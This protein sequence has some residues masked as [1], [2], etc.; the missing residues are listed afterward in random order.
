MFSQ[1]DFLKLKDPNFLISDKPN[2][3]NKSEV[4]KLIST[5]RVKY[6][7]HIYDPQPIIDSLQNNKKYLRNLKK[8]FD[9]T[10]RKNCCNCISLVLYSKEDDDSEIIDKYLPSIQKTI[11]NVSNSLPDFIV[12]IYIETSVLRMLNN[13]KNEKGINILNNFYNAENVEIYTYFCKSLMNKKKDIFEDILGKTRTFRYLAMTDPTTN[14]CA[15]REC[16]GFV[17]NLDCHNLKLFQN[18]NKIFY[19]SLLWSLQGCQTIYSSYSSWTSFYKREIN[20][21]YYSKYNNIYDILG[22]GFSI[23][24]K[25][26]E[27]AYY[28]SIEDVDR[29]LTAYLQ[30]PKTEYFN[31]LLFSHQ[32]EFLR[33]FNSGYDEI[34]LLNLFRDQIS[35]KFKGKE[36]VDYNAKDLQIAKS[37]VHYN[38]I[39]KIYLDSLQPCKIIQQLINEKIIKNDLNVPFDRNSCFDIVEDKQEFMICVIFGTLNWIDKFLIA[40][41]IQIDKMFTIEV[42]NNNV[43]DLSNVKY[44]YIF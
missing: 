43:L 24:L 5:R 33:M 38:D 10:K 1:Y 42:F 39:K 29:Q 21:E 7:V 44:N 9:L 16:D 23:K 8:T 20:K 3:L 14:I 4:C 31:N 6:Y 18:S 27:E 2:P 28:K 25:V 40:D 41:N 17:T 30:N 13:T 34:F 19:F 12:R 15:M 22:G 37:M 35:V 26:K 11:E 36:F 32:D